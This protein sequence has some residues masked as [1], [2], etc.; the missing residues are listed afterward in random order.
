MFVIS[1]PYPLLKTTVLL[2]SALEGNNRAL[3]S[4]V[5][6]LRAVDGTLRTY[7]LRKR[8]RKAHNWDFLVSADKAREVKEF[9]RLYTG[10]VMRV[11]DNNGDA[12]LGWMTMN[13]LELKGEGRAGGW[14][15]DEAYQIT[16]RLDERV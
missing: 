10:S 3:Q 11:V 8:G 13:P 12:Y 6:T 7:I 9:I 5:Q 1:A 4:S 2:P 16:L 14:P 15:G